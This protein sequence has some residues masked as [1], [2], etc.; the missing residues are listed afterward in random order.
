MKKEKY[1]R[2]TCKS[3]IVVPH[4]RL[5]QDVTSS[6]NIGTDTEEEETGEVKGEI[7]GFEFSWE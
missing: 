1:I 6:D 2:P 7:N 5:L 4:G 3:R